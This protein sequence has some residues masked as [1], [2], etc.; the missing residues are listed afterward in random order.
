MGKL[1]DAVRGGDERRT[2]EE[3]RDVVA[4]SLENECS[5]R[6]MAAL[7]KR[8]MEI[9]REIKALPSEE[10]V[11]PVDAMAAFVAEYDEY[12]DP[13]FEDDDG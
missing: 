8:L 11:N 9:C 4:T 1:L 3:L 13:R 5:P 12:E 2:L 10:D 7:S 6:D